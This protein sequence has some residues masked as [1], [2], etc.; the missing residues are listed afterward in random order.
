M[1]KKEFYFDLQ[2]CSSNLNKIYALLKGQMNYG[3]F[4]TKDPKMGPVL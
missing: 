2:M 3:G 4:R 1:F